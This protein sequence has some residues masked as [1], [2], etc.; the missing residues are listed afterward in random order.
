MMAACDNASK[1]AHTLEHALI[2]HMYTSL[3]FSILKLFEPLL[4]P[5]D[6]LGPIYYLSSW[7]SSLQIDSFG[8]T[9]VEHHQGMRAP[10]A[11]VYVQVFNKANCDL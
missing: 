5:L 10:V 1:N 11:M 9:I 4:P 6:S 3:L 7:L 8:V 2:M